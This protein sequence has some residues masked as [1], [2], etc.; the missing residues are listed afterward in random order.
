MKDIK[1]KIVICTSSKKPNENF[2]P[3]L[4]RDSVIHFWDPAHG[5]K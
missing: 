4:I 2:I 5:E 3:C 1:T